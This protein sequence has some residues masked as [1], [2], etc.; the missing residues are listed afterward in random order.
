MMPRHK[1][2]GVEILFEDQD[3]L[4]VN[5][6]AGLLSIPG[7]D[8][9]EPSVARMLQQRY[10]TLHIVHR[11]DRDT[12]G[13]LVFT[14]NEESHRNLSQQFEERKVTKIYLALV[15][16]RPPEQIF[17]IDARLATDNRGH[18]IVSNT[19]KPAVTH[20]KVLEMFPRFTLIEVQPLTGRQHQIRVHLAHIGLPLAVDPLYGSPRPLSISEVKP[21]ARNAISDPEGRSSCLL[22]RTPLHALSLSISHPVLGHSVQFTAELPKDMQATLRQLRKWSR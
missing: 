21:G 9:D 14:K 13:I 2:K 15:R 20:C 11:L 6:P 5:K 3:L 8:L 4:V 17:R 12:T 16:G 10:P 7:R 18:A 22:S 1:H 19:G